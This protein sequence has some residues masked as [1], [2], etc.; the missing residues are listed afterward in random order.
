MAEQ[1]Q[2]KP[3]KQS[4]ADF[5]PGNRITNR[6]QEVFE[7]IRHHEEQCYLVKFLETGTLQYV[8]VR[9]LHQAFDHSKP[10]VSGVGYM[11][12]DNP[13]YMK[14]GDN[15]RIYQKWFG[16]IKRCYQGDDPH[17]ENVTVCEEWHNFYNFYYWMTE[18]CKV[19]D[20]GWCIDKDLF[21]PADHKMYSPET[22]CLIPG[23]INS[24]IQGLSAEELCSDTLTQRT[25]KSSRSLSR[26]LVTYEDKLSERVKSTLW[27]MCEKNGISREIALCNMRIQQLEKQMNDAE[28]KSANRIA[29][30]EAQNAD[31]Q[32]QV[33]FFE[34]KDF[35]G[36]QLQKLYRTMPV[37]G[38]VEH[39]GKIYRL[40]AAIDLYNILSQ[41]S[42]AMIGAP[43]P[44]R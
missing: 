36:E 8:N 9:N 31:L 11:R 4:E 41:V 12:S 13:I 5:K 35:D 6:K 44:E 10:Y 30:L 22:C 17:Y 33:R 42:T 26:L 2:K 3:K 40:D 20:P 29:E 25:Q 19:S 18:Q 14:D 21:S 24:A 1:K 23:A 37:R 34:S 39:G 16:M 32:K 27:N 43:R 15:A 38:F 7:I 28:K